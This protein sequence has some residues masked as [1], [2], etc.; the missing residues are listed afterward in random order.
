M[1]AI[2]VH[3]VGGPEQLVVEDVDVPLPGPGEVLLRH[4][5]VGLN[6][7]DVYHR[8]GL[9]P[10]TTPFTPGLEGA[11]VVEAVG[12]DVTRFSL[13]DHVAYATPPVG[14]YAEMRTIDADRVIKLP[15]TIDAK[16]AAAA[17]LKGMTAEYLLRRTYRVHAGETILVHAAAGGVGSL[18]CQWAKQLGATVIGTVGSAEK[19]ERARAFG[20]D[21]PLIYKDAAWVDQVRELTDGKGVSVVYDG[22]GKSTFEQSLRCLRSRGMFV[23]YG[24]ASGA[25][26]AFEPSVL[27]KYGSLFFT[28]PSLMDYIATRAELEA[29]AAALFDVIAAGVVKVAVGQTFPLADAAQAHRALE[30]RETTGSTL[31]LP[32]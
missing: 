4:E 31:L 12:S 22:V 5:A 15:G 20:C 29:S 8:S 10:L 9:Y 7:I 16:T 11:G 25:V 18:M 19:A 1:L 23:S 13:G 27:V 2:R 14:A 24:N 6:Y 21:H 26:P 30:A 28:R 32:G 3:A 17:M